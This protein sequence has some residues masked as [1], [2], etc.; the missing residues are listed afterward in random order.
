MCSFRAQA[1]E[2]PTLK[3]HLLA[4]NVSTFDESLLARQSLLA[5]ISQ[6]APTENRCHIE[7]DNI[8]EE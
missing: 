1:K 6:S 5:K 3:V 4:N 8:I 7:F 2:D